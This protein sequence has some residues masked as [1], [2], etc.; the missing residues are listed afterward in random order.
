MTTQETRLKKAHVALLKN[1]E[2]SLYSGV[3]LMGKSS[4]IDD[5][6]TAYTDGVNKKYGRKFID[7]LSDSE[8]RGLVMH[9]NLHVAL[10]HIHRFMPE[11]KAE[12]T[13]INASADYVVNDIIMNFKAET[14]KLPQGALYDK[15]F[16]NW[17]VR[18]V[19]EFL[20]KEQKQNKD[21]QS[22]QGEGQGSGDGVAS[23]CSVCSPSKVRVLWWDTEVHKE[24]VF[25][26][27]YNNIASLL[28]PEGGGGTH[29][30]CV[31]K[32][33]TDNKVNSEAVLVF[34]DGYVENDIEWTISTPT[35]WVVT[36]RRD[37]VA[38]SGQ[39]IRKES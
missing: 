2:T 22:Q 15:Q 1:P 35:L 3:I 21:K 25:E 38:P 9:E 31:N 14:C 13:L 8:L 12:P 16:H 39:V 4:V 18:E 24:Q 30:S 34:T 6:I 29:V 26:G 17:S 20:K 32:Y 19:Y 23:I 10:K 7:K 36:Q 11:F 37:F 28:K 27:D 33:L 5:E